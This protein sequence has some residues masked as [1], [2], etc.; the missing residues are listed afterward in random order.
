MCNYWCGLK[1]FDDCLFNLGLRLKK[2]RDNSLPLKES[3]KIGVVI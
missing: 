2:L 3:T 1:D